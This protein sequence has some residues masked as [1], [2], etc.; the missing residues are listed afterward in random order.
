M[1]EDS[2]PQTDLSI[3]C[4]EVHGYARAIRIRPTEFGQPSDSW[5]HGE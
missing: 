2:W 4:E 3:D 1:S 5:E